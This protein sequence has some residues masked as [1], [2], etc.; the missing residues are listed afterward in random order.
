MGRT[1]S[2]WDKRELIKYEQLLS[3]AN[4]ERFVPMLMNLLPPST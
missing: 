3:Y 4:A 2:E 1:I